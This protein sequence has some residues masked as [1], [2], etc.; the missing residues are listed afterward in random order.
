MVPRVGE[1]IDRTY[2]AHAVECDNR[3]RTPRQT[4]PRER[5]PC[6]NRSDGEDQ[7]KPDDH[8]GP[9]EVRPQAWERGSQGHEDQ[10]RQRVFERFRKIMQ[11]LVEVVLR[12][13][14]PQNQ[15]GYERG[16]KAISLDQFGHSIG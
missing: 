6:R 15:A 11:S 8:L 14:S 1:I 12:F 4:H 9:S 5:E 16:N 3:A 2:P 10:S 13:L 7:G